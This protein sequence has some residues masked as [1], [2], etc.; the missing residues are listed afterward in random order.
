MTTIDEQVLEVVLPKKTQKTIDSEYSSLLVIVE[1]LTALDTEIKVLED[2]KDKK[3]KEKLLELKDS[4][5]R[6]LSHLQLFV[7]KPYFEGKDM[8]PIKDTIVL[9]A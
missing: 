7:D 6:N 9:F 8:Q 2:S 4:F 3:D 5:Y 1:Y